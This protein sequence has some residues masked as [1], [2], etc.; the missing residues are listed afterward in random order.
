[1]DDTYRGTFQFHWVVM[2]SDKLFQLNHVNK[3]KH[4][5]YSML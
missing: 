3:E 2:I 5:Y 4:Y 1:M